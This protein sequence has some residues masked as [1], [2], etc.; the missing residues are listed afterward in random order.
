MKQTAMASTPSAA[1]AAATM[2]SSSS[3][4]AVITVPSAVMR[5]L[6][7]RRNRLGTRGMGF[8]HCK[9][10][11]SGVRTR[12]ISRTSRK[13]LLVIRPVF[14]PCFCS[15][16]LEPTVVPWRTSSRSDGAR[17]ARRNKSQMPSNTATS[18]RS[19]VEAH[20]WY[21]MPPPPSLNARSV[22]VPPIS[23]PIRAPTPIPTIPYG[24]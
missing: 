11:M 8:S 21:Q 23:T 4:S 12:P 22:H 2:Y 16:V 13:P 3:S 17:S 5:S 15:N 10:N 1:N 14:A 6:T 24:P 7:S 19:G 20:L 9:S 18:G